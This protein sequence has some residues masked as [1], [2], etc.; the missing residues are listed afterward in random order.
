[1]PD[2]APVHPPRQTRWL[3]ALGV[4]LLY[5]AGVRGWWFNRPFQRDA[6]GCASYFGILARNYFR[7]DFSQTLGVP[8]CSL[9]HSPDAPVFYANHPPLVAMG[10]AATYGAFGYRGSFDQLPPDW[11]VRLPA[12]LF[13]LGCIGL[14]YWM[15]QSRAGPRAGFVAAA[16]F[17]ATPISVIFG[18]LA[19]VIDTQ[20]VFFC[21]LAVEAYLRLHARPDAKHFVLAALPLIP[22]GFT[23]WVAFYLLPVFLVHWLLTRPRKTWPW[24]IGLCAV[25]TGVF[26]AAYVQIYLVRHDPFWIKK[27]FLHRSGS[28][29]SDSGVKYD[30]MGWIRVALFVMNVRQHTWWLIGIAVAWMAIDGWR[31]RAGTPAATLARLLIAWAALHVLVGRQGVYNHD[32]WWWPV[33][34]ALVVASALLVERACVAL[35][36]QQFRGRTIDAWLGVLLVA[37]AAWNTVTRLHPMVGRAYE[38][39]GLGYSIREIGL[40]IR[41]AAPPDRAVIIAEKD[42]TVSLWYYA[43]RPIIQNVWDSVTLADRMQNDRLAELPWNDYYQPLSQ[44]PAGM[45]V[46]VPYVQVVPKFVD[47]LQSHYPSI[48]PPPQTPGPFLFFDLTR[49][50]P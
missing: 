16:L 10:I 8:V 33:T 13:L 26:V 22:A 20:L 23:D 11:Q 44:P 39:T 2:P 37:F 31:L 36:A 24:I 29:Q 28:G 34:P 12:S 19:D 27:E 21:L 1:M 41:A 42:P 49:R 5:A 45:V 4:V 46:P 30:A 40:A 18:G 17:A 14:I 35:E 32:W 50:L 15:V 38:T 3:I 9:G 48:E 47:Y 25:G 6:E 7:Y 43:D